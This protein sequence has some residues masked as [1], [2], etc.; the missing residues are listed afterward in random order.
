MALKDD[1]FLEMVNATTGTATRIS[2]SLYIPEK[3]HVKSFSQFLIMTHECNSLDF[4]HCGALFQICSSF[5]HFNSFLLY[6]KNRVGDNERVKL[7]DFKNVL[8]REDK[9][10]GRLVSKLVKARALI[11][12]DNRY[13]YFVSPRFIIMGGYVDCEEFHMLSKI[14]PK[15][16]K[17][18][19][20]SQRKGYSNWK[21]AKKEDR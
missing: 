19:D 21:I 8:S 13:R 16:R 6:K 20:D 17:C 2:G 7:Q 18:L 14:D 12:P 3:L 10:T 5:L 4:E 11:K 15:I 9:A 1:R